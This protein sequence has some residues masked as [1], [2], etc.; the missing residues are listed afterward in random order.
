MHFVLH[1]LILIY[2]YYQEFKSQESYEFVNIHMKIIKIIAL[3]VTNSLSEI[4]NIWKKS[5]SRQIKDFL[6]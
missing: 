5:S 6:S 3:Y 1:L 2:K 4:F